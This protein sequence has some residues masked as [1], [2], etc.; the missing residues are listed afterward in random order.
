MTDIFEIVLP[1][2]GLIALGY[3]VARTGILS[4]AVGDG[5]AAYVFTIAV[6]VLL[7]RTLATATFTGASPWAYWATYF[8]AVIA[9]WWL[10]SL[11]ITQVFDRGRRAAVIAGVSAAFSNL[12]LLGIPLVERA[13]GQEGLNVLFLLVSVHLPIMMAASTFLMEF[14]VRADGVDQTRLDFRKTAKNLVQSFAKNPIIIGIL[15]G[16]I[17]RFTGMGIAGPVRQVIDLVGQ[18]AGPVALFSLGMGLIK[19]GIKGNIWPAA[20]ISVL[21]LLAMPALAFALGAF[22]FSLPPLWFKV[23][24]LAAACP[25][26]MNAYLIATYFRIAEGLATNAIVLSLIGSILSVPFWL[27]LSIWYAG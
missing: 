15:L 4:E 14:A 26:G 25:T 8:C 22:V 18:T 2:F 23:T 6:P 7:L 5:L 12:V 9:V 20:C 11:L 24:V 3:A 13:Y 17:W 21:S 16:G 19:Y 27:T 10:A 1:V